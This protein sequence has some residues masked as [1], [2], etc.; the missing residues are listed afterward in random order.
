MKAIYKLLI[1]NILF[2]K[3]SFLQAQ[4]V[5]LTYSVY[6]SAFAG[7]SGSDFRIEIN[8]QKDF[9]NFR[10]GRIDSVQQTKLRADLAFKACADTLARTNDL[11]AEA[12]QALASR[13]TVMLDRYKVYKWD[14]LQLTATSTFSSLLDSIYISSATQ[15]ERRAENKTRITLDGTS[16]YLTVLNKDTSIMKAYAHSPGPDSHPLFYRLLHE[17]LQLYRQQRPAALLDIHYTN[18][19]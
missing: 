6:I 9:I 11:S 18:G 16:F 10:F 3:P 2:I 13:L 7:V 5:P 15:L 1:I 4:G 12:K 8:R 17:S 19:Y 14:G